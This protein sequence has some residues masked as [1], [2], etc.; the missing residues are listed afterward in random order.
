MAPLWCPKNLLQ[1][2]R[3]GDRKVAAEA[4]TLH[5]RFRFHD[6]KIKGISDFEG[7]KQEFSGHKTRSM[8]ERYNHTA[9]KVVLLNKAR[10]ESKRDTPTDSR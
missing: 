7:D 4:G 10:I 6:L 9:D 5:N 1:A 2:V 3:P 8:M